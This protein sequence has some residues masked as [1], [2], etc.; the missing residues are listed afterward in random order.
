VGDNGS[1]KVEFAL[2]V[3]GGPLEAQAL[4]LVESLRRFGGHHARATV[5]VA[6]PRRS[7][8]PS[9][10]TIRALRRL[11]A[12]YLALDLS[13]ACPAYP[14]SWRVHA[15]ATLECR[16]GPEV[17][18]Q[19]DSDTLFLGD[20]GPLC[21][22]AQASARPVD[23]KGMGTTGPGDAFE[24]YWSALCRLAGI[25]LETL[26]F[27]TATVDGTPVRATHN[28]GFVAARRTT[29]LFALADEFFRRSVDADLRPHAGSRL[30]V[31]AGTGEVGVAGSEWWGSSQ[32]AA[33]VAAASLGITIVPLDECINVPVHLWDRL[34]RKP[35]SV[36]HA[37]YHW[38]L[39]APLSRPNPLLDGS[40][41]L[42]DDVAAWLQSRVPLQ[43]GARRSVRSFRRR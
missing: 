38:M 17:I 14:T 35:K 25:D 4:L 18:V 6:S 27:V 26:P 1:P 31:V 42:A 2:L 29:G 20:V 11:G 39:G 19:L 43:D 9:R 5:T 15:M 33:S 7:R 16:P 36:I 3:E 13:G 28:G 10:T 8:R 21:V 32:A 37:H 34:P 41:A 23:V 30:N 40:V 24:P 12:E 22:D